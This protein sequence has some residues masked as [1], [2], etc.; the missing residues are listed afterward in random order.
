MAGNRVAPVHEYVHENKL[1][2]P[3][4]YFLQIFLDLL[5]LLFQRRPLILDLLLVWESVFP[6]HQIFCMSFAL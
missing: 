5:N 3:A 2:F 6:T 4:L 1:F